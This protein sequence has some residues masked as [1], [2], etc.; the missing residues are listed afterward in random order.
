MTVA[1]LLGSVLTGCSPASTSREHELPNQVIETENAEQQKAHGIEASE[2]P[3]EPQE[4][5]SQP[6]ER[7]D[8]P[9]EA[10]EGPTTEDEPAAGAPPAQIETPEAIPFNEV[11]ARSSRDN[12]W[13]VVLGDVY[14]FTP[15]VQQHPFGAQ[16]TNAVCGKDATETFQENTDI[17]EVLTRLETVYLGPVMNG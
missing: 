3:A 9:A 8:E 5:A 10:V 4:A 7:Q 2:V 12:C 13:I 6:A 14:D 16:L 17:N 15:F 1:L 11:E